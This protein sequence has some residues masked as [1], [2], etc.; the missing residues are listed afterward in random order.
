M[1]KGKSLENYA[2]QHG[3]KELGHASLHSNAQPHQHPTELEPPRPD[4]GKAQ[5]TL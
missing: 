1:G 2:N 4:T 5:Q 3:L